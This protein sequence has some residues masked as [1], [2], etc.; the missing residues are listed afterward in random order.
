MKNPKM[1]LTRLKMRQKLRQNFK[2]AKYAPSWRIFSVLLHFY[3]TISSKIGFSSLNFYEKVKCLL[4]FSSQND[5]KMRQT[6]K[7]CAKRVQIATFWRKCAKSG[8]SVADLW[9]R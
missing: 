1:R 2:S 6:Q 4:I 7:S 3:A 8:K 9:E 5:P